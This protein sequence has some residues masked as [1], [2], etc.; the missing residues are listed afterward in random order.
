[1]GRPGRRQPQTKRQ[2]EQGKERGTQGGGHG[3]DVRFSMK[4]F[5]LTYLA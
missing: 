2:K 1:M 3:G 4:L 5:G